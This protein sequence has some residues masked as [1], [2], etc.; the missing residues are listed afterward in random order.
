[1]REVLEVATACTRAARG[2]SVPPSCAF[3]AS[4]A[5]DKTRHGSDP[6]ELRSAAVL[7]SPWI[8]RV[9]GER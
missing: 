8:V 9:R 7:P 4:V 6:V 3:H 1:M 2:V 5:E